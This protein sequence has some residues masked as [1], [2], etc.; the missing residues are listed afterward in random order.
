MAEN[1][2]NVINEIENNYQL[3]K[4]GG[5]FDFTRRNSFDNIEERLEYFITKIY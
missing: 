3:H 4:T 2:N 5:L 1:F